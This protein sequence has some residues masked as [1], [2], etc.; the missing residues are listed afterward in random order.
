M[1][2][3]VSS[4]YTVRLKS[5]LIKPLIPNVLRCEKSNKTHENIGNYNNNGKTILGNVHKHICQVVNCIPLKHCTN[6]IG[7]VLFPEGK[8]FNMWYGS[9]QK[10][11]LVFQLKKSIVF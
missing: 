1:G 9:L 5:G 10:Y 7:I 11:M 4:S 6:L 8:N 3:V 2:Y